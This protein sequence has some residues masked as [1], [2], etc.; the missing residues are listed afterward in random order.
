[1]L[2]LVSEEREVSIK[3]VVGFSGSSKL[4]AQSL[5]KLKQ[6]AQELFQLASLFETYGEL[7]DINKLKK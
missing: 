6:E 7:L 5:V 4:L 3:T 2:I 1:M